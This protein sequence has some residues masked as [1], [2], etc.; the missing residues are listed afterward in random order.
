MCLNGGSLTPAQPLVPQFHPLRNTSLPSPH[1]LLTYRRNCHLPRRG[2]VLCKLSLPSAQHP[3][4]QSRHIGLFGQRRGAFPAAHAALLGDPVGGDSGAWYMTMT[5]TTT[6]G[7][8]CE[9]DS[10]CSFLLRDDIANRI[11]YV[12]RYVHARGS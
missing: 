11:L 8:G 1:S 6:D 2:Y 9:A 3:H 12:S 10:S 5:L 4:S 7:L